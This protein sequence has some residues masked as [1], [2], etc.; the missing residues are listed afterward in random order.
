M[1]LLLLGGGPGTRI[2]LGCN[3]GGTGSTSSPSFVRFA[4]ALVGAAGS[5]IAGA[6]F[7]LGF[8]RGTSSFSS[9]SSVSIAVSTSALV[10]AA[11]SVIVL[12][13]RSL[14]L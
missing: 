6:A 2:S 4:S 7:S 10:A 12:G 9:P 13:F 1:L 5:V 14:S 8:A 3:R 11:G